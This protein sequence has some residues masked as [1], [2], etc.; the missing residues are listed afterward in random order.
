MDRVHVKERMG[1]DRTYSNHDSGCD[2]SC[3]RHPKQMS[4]HPPW[5]RDPVLVQLAGKYRS[6]QLRMQ[7]IQEK[8]Q[9]SH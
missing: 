8:G 2:S 6:N 7:V 9:T 3:L 4:D 1:E 5:S